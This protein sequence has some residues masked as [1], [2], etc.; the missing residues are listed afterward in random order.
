MKKF[1]FVVLLISL[2]VAMQSCNQDEPIRGINIPPKS[3]LDDSEN[4]GGTYSYV[5]DTTDFQILVN[6]GTY[7]FRDSSNMYHSYD[8]SHID[9]TAEHAPLNYSNLCILLCQPWN[10][11][12]KKLLI[13][14]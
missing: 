13:T 4:L 11:K 9:S 3:I 1:S 2:V 5:L 8:Y 12:E 10:T 14:N 7:Y 6:Y